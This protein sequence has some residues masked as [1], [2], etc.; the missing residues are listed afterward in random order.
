MLVPY[1]SDP[2]SLNRY[3]YCHNNPVNRTDPSGHKS[4]WK[5]FWGGVQD[6]VRDYGG[7]FGLSGGLAN[8]IINNNWQPLKNQLIAGATAFVFSGFNPIATMAAMVTT[9]FLDSKPGQQLTKFFAAE[10]MDDM[11]GEFWCHTP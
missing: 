2:Q 7:L 1:P 10:V 3:S 8:G 4:W 9:S 5:K 6:F 11:L